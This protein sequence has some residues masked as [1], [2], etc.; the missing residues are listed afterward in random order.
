MNKIDDHRTG[1]YLLIALTIIDEKGGDCPSS[2]LTAEMSK[3][4]NLSSYEKSLNNSGQPRWVTRFRFYS[5]G[6]VK[7][8]WIKKEH[9][10]WYLTEKG[11]QYKNCNPDQIITITN[12][13]YD[14]WSLQK[15][16]ENSDSLIGKESVDEPG[17]LM[18]I[19]PD[20]VIFRDLINGVSS[21]KIQIPPF[22]RSFVWES[23]D[24]SFLLDSIYRGYPIGSFIFWKTTR[25]LP[26]SRNVGNIKLEINQFAKGSEINYVLDGQQRITSLFSAVKGAT[27]DN[28]IYRF[29][30]DLKSKRFIVKRGDENHSYIDE[31]IDNLQIS[32]ET[33]FTESRSVYRNIIRKY[34]VEY[35]EVLDNIYD[36][37]VGYRFSIISVMDKETNDEDEKNEGIKQVVEMFSRINE[38][39]RK[40]TVVAKMVARCWGA[41]YDLSEA[42]EDFY[43]LHKELNDIREQTL[44]QSA[45]AILNHRKSKSKDILSTKI[46]KLES[47]WDNITVAFLLAIE[48]VKTKLKIHNLK[49][50]PFESLLVPL[51]YLF[52][53]QKSLNNKQTE[54]IEIW[55][56]RACLSNRYD[57]TVE[58]KLEE[59]CI[60][61]DK[62]L[63]NK[64]PEFNYLIDWDQLANKLIGQRYNLKNAFVKTVLSLYSHIKPQNLTDGRDVKFEGLFSGYYK[65]NLHHIF[66]QAYLRKVFPEYKDY[67]DS[68]VN[69]MLIPAITNLE[70]LDKQPSDYFSLLRK[71]DDEF[72]EIL[73]HHY[74]DNL[75]KSGILENDFM[76][77]LSY[78]AERLVEEFRLKT[79]ITSKLQS[80]FSIN[81]SKP[82]DIL[83]TRIRSFIHENLKNEYDSSYWEERIPVDI[84]EVVNKKIKDV[85]KRHPYGLE[86]YNRDDVKIQFLDVMDYSK[87]LI[88]NWDIFGSSLGS[89][90][91][92]L[93]HFIS[94]KHYRNA[95]KHGRSLNEVDKRTGEAAVLWFENVLNNQK[96][97]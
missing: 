18:D 14:K 80:H 63:E 54:L 66:P 88:S 15:D 42:F 36:R 78:R 49:Y 83:E 94:L 12:N 72:P 50:L 68:I 93:Q 25:K 7:A 64:K 35:E 77:F 65:H 1:E 6:L 44:L 51:T 75:Q 24:I 31:D 56:W 59:D 57:S 5:I 60:N 47:E 11:K 84:R 74:I 62:I 91:E 26:R 76:K 67:F 28:D 73:Q 10:I 86:E 21:G 46:H 2:E 41:G 8:D 17:A 53:K 32:I 29:L 38:T 20:Y 48:F 22:Q 19:K 39:G 52:Y 55:F 37:F 4:L 9:R 96:G 13:A 97:V 95:I 89:K 87:I 58:S 92:T 43:S 79:G 81:P 33:I 71:N 61:F 30:F 69:I 45:S 85:V 82:I 27:I 90:Q 40:L 34:P 16:T 23:R 3:R 70:I